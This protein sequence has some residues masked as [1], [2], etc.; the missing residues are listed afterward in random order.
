MK[1]RTTCAISLSLL[2]ASLVLAQHNPNPSPDITAQEVL[3][4]IKYLASDQLQGR[5]AGTEFADKAAEYVAEEFHQYGLKP[6]MSDGSFFQEFE[7]VS[8]VKL[9][10]KNSLAVNVA[11]KS[12][13]YLVISDFTPLA[14]SKDTSVTG[15]VVFAGYGIAAKDLQYDDYAG[16]D[17]NGKI[18]LVLQYG[19][20]GDNP[21]GKFSKYVALRLKAMTARE[22]GASALLITTGPM[23]DE[24]DEL[25]K[26]RYDLA[27]ADAG[28]PCMHIKRAVAD[29]ILGSVGR[30]VKETQEKLRSSQKPGSFPVSGVS[31]SLTSDVQ[32]QRSKT[33]NVIGLLPGSDEKLKDEYLVIGAHYDHLGLG[34]AGSLVPDTVAVHH[35]ADDNA[36]GTAGVLELAQAFV[37]R[38]A[39]LKRSL[40]FMSFGAEEEGDLGSDYFVKHPLVPLHRIVG[41]INLDE[42][43]R[44]K[45]STLI[46]YGT[47]TSPLWDTLLTKFNTPRQFN[48]KLNPEGFGPSDHASFYAK[49]IPV[50]FFFTGVHPDYHKPSD[51]WDKINVDGEQA[52]LEYVEKIALEVADRGEKPV[53]ARVDM[54]RQTGG[55][56]GLRVYFGTVPDFAEQVDGLKVSAVRKGSPAEKAGVMGG[57]IITMFGGKTIKNIY[58]Y[59]YALQDFKPGDEVELTVKRGDKVLHL[60]GVL[61]RRSN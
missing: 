54:P 47:G 4:H 35:G 12:L 19:P 56:A 36:S 2:F 8:G 50:L 40:L 27:F 38:E 58:D 26:L 14:F 51:T 32:K 16:M 33:K 23:D 41:M 30:S 61:E 20:D 43:G 10:E 59:T 18:V 31:V 7:F 1:T 3:Y 48:L 46:V 29:S 52:I 5:R 13:S 42:V 55:T 17:I 11:G 9:G 34:G 22:K 28:I 15:E 49:D 6:V 60:K 37:P 39:A 45:D 21:H 53:F 57:D 25:M 44:E 24:K